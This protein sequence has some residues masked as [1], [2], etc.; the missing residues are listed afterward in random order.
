MNDYDKEKW[1]DLYKTAMLEL[2][3]VT[4]TGR[5]ANARSEITVHLE[6]LKQ[7]PSLHKQEYQAI[8]DALGNLRVLEREEERLVAQDQK[9]ILKETVDKLQTIVPKFKDDL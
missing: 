4:M 7:H 8:Q 6:T 3:R 9:R 2:Q 1:F 5:I